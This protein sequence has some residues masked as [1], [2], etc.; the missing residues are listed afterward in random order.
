MDRAT[1]HY[2]DTDLVLVFIGFS[3]LASREIAKAPKGRWD[4]DQ[5]LWLIQYGRIKGTELEK[6]IILYA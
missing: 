3:D 5:K 2:T 4:P 6:H 1:P